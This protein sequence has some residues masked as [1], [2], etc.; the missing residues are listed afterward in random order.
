MTTR[1]KK[2]FSDIEGLEQSLTDET[3]ELNPSFSCTEDFSDALVETQAEKKEERDLITEV[4][5]KAEDK[6]VEIIEQEPERQPVQ[7]RPRPPALA[8]RKPPKNTP[9]FSSKIR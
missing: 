6:G 3:F 1:K 5:K 4:T 2:E 8:K 9:K 7:V